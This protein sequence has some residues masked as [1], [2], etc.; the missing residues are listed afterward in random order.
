MKHDGGK[1]KE[2]KCTDFT[3][4]LAIAK[5]SHNQMLISLMRNLSEIMSETIRETRRVLLYSEE[6]EDGLITAHEDIFEAIKCRDTKKAEK[7]ML[8]HLVSVQNQLFKHVD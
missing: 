5:G 2:F 6:T 1:K 8:N 3:F 4:H 7:A